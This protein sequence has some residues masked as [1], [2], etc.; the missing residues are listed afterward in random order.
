MAAKGCIPVVSTRTHRGA[1][2][3]ASGRPANGKILEHQ[4]GHSTRLI[5]PG[6]HLL[7]HL[8]AGHW[9]H[10]LLAAAIAAALC[11]ALSRR[12]GRRED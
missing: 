1:A 11:G 8:A 4:I 10:W 3:L 2:P 5:R 6:L 9:W 12:G 7:H